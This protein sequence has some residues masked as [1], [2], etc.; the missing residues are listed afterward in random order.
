M[1]FDELV[2]VLAAACE[3]SAAFGASEAWVA[4]AVA[5]SELPDRFRM[6]AA[7]AEIAA[8]VA[9]PPVAVIECLA[10]IAAG[11]GPCCQARRSRSS[12]TGCPSCYNACM[13]S[14]PRTSSAIQHMLRRLGRL[15]YA[16]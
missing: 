5:N 11:L 6:V 16:G 3:A 2:V 13:A 7:A 14:P 8:V 15:D 1:H 12:C 9:E 10:V 4:C